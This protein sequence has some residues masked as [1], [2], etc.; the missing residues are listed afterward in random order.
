MYRLRRTPRPARPWRCPIDLRLRYRLAHRE[1]RNALL[2]NDAI[3][4]EQR[5]RNMSK[6]KGKNT[7]PEMIVRSACYELGFAIVYTEAT[8]RERQTWYSRSIDYVY[9]FTVFLA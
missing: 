2:E 9:S 7:K 5:S 1:L 8:Y 6:I 4:P 3:T